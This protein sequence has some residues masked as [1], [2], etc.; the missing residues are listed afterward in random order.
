MATNKAL[1]SD[2]YEPN[3]RKI[4]FESYAYYPTEYDKILNVQSVD[5]PY[6]EDYKMGG[7]GNVPTKAEG[8]PIVYDDPV[9]GS[10]VRFDWTPYGKGF[11]VTYEAQEDDKYGPM[12]KM[13]ASLGKAFRNQTELEGIKLLDNA[14]TVNGGFDTLPLCATN[15]PLLR[16]G[17]ARNEPTAATDL[18]VTALQDALVDFERIVDESGVPVMIRPKWLVVPPEL[19]PMAREILGS[20]FKPYTADNEI[21][22]IQQYGLGLFVS[23]YMTVGNGAWFILADK[24]D[25]DL[26]Y[27]WRNKFSVDSDVDFDTGDGKMKGYMRMGTGWGDWRGVWGS[28][29]V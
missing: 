3:L 25:H 16:G 20:Q 7:F 8:T 4:I 15:H 12:K 29:G 2:L 19:A 18:S 10:R 5:V 22:I 14:F 17:T 6:I 1:F 9:P 23:H 27:F 26:Q 13:A 11:R 21:N 24:S 28:P